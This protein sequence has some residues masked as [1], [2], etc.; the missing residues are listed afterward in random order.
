MDKTV[1]ENLLLEIKGCTFATIDAVTQPAVG[2]TKT[3][4]GLRVLLFTNKYFSGYEAMLRRRLI[5]AGKNPDNF[6]LGDLPWGTRIP[7]TPLIEHKGEIYLQCIELAPGRERITS[8]ITGNEFTAEQLGLKEHHKQIGLSDSDKV[9]V[10]CY[11]IENITRI[12]LLNEELTAEAP[13][14]AILRLNS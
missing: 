3:T 10:R 8:N 13:K 12:A 5:A 6:S 2:Y 4:T 1:L 9:I 7:E 14:R 11:N